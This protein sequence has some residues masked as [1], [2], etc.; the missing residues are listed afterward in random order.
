MTPLKTLFLSD[1]QGEIGSATTR[2]YFFGKP[3][4]RQSAGYW[5][6]LGAGGSASRSIKKPPNIWERLRISFLCLLHLK[7]KRNFLAP[8]HVV[9]TLLQ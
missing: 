4:P 8:P 3:A 6:G 2:P 9:L 7:A 5:L 1:I